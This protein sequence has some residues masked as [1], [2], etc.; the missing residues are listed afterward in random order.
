MSS[1]IDQLVEYLLEHPDEHEVRWRLC[2]KLYAARDYENVLPHLE[3]LKSDWKPRRNV[4]RYLAATYY[5]LKEYDQ[6][7]KLLQEAVERWPE[8]SGLREQLA[9]VYEVS[10]NAEAAAREWEVMYRLNPERSSAA[11]AVDRLRQPSSGGD[12]DTEP[13]EIGEASLVCPECGA[14]NSPDFDLCF[15]C[16]ALLTLSPTPTP[17]E[18]D[19]EPQFPIPSTERLILSGI[20]SVVVVAGAAYVTLRYVLP[21]LLFGPRGAVGVSL[22]E[23]V[24]LALAT[25]R[26]AAGLAAFIVC[27]VALWLAVRIIRSPKLAPGQPWTVGLFAA[28][29]LYLGQ[30]A[31]LPFLPYALVAA[32]AVAFLALIISLPLRPVPR[33]A[34]SFSSLIL[35]IVASGSAFVMMAGL[36]PFTDQEAH[37]VLRAN[38]VAQGSGSPRRAVTPY[39]VDHRFTSTGSPWLDQ[40]VG[41]VGFDM[42]ASSPTAKLHVRYLDAAGTTIQETTFEGSGSIGARVQTG[43]VYRLMIES[44]ANSEVTVRPVSAMRIVYSP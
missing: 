10:G 40:L 27:P 13:P 39:A 25:P 5:R 14:K 24:H 34:I 7:I 4:D 38:A 29:A 44:E 16:R 15:R 31:P 17:I 6:S 9:R 22:A 37:D 28:G 2:K 30:W 12:G 42:E 8:E 19:S 3:Q 36:E 23:S 18:F 33:I 20:A 32:I 11:N 41:A 35:T 21:P 26:A 1:S 43:L